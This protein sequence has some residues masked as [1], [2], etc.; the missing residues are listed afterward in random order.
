M[1]GLGIVV[2]ASSRLSRRMKNKKPPTEWVKSILCLVASI[3][4]N[5]LDL[6]PLFGHGEKKNFGIVPS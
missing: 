4:Y 2:G 5:F 6:T 3:V 1:H